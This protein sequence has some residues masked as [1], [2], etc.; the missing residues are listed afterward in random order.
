MRL[1]SILAVLTPFFHWI[2]LAPG[3]EDVPWEKKGG[4]ENGWCAIEECQWRRSDAPWRGVALVLLF[5]AKGKMEK[6]GRG[7]GQRRK[8]APAERGDETDERDNWRRAHMPL[9]FG[10][11]WCTMAI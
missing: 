10:L 11:S 6:K 5:L 4:G 1:G 2:M 9:I 3:P 7:C 8:E